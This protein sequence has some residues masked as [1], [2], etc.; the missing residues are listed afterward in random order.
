M[1]ALVDHYLD[2]IDP[3]PEMPR[4]LRIATFSLFLGSVAPACLAL[5]ASIAGWGALVWRLYL[6]VSITLVVAA[7]SL[8]YYSE[9]FRRRLLEDLVI[10]AASVTSLAYGAIFIVFDIG[11]QRETLVSVVLWGLLGLVYA[12]H[13]RERVLALRKARESAPPISP[14]TPQ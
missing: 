13:L 12:S 9:E 6:L 2:N 3:I 10:L 4:S 1:T 7:V 11:L 5:V 14:G 8:G